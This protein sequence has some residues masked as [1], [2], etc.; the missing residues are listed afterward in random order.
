MIILCDCDSW[1]INGIWLVLN[2]LMRALVSIFDCLGTWVELELVASLALQIVFTNFPSSIK[3]FKFRRNG[4][5]CANF[6]RRN[7]IRRNGHK[8]S[9][10]YC[11]VQRLTYPIYTSDLHKNKEDFKNTIWYL[12]TKCKFQKVVNQ[13]LKSSYMTLLLLWALPIFSHQ[14]LSTMSYTTILPSESE[15][16]SHEKKSIII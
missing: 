13:M 4:T 15:I 8:L 14:R 12:Q 6:A 3:S 5:T 7:G 11:Y 2:F 10:S 9:P 16:S 1:S